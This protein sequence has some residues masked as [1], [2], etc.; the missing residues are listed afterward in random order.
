[1]QT[2]V[3]VDAKLTVKPDE[4]VAL[5][6]K[7]AVPS[8]WFDSDPNVMV[9]L[10]GVPPEICVTAICWPRRVMC[11]V[12][13][14][15]DVFAVKEKLTTPFEMVP[16]VSQVWSLAGAKSPLRDVAAGSTGSSEPAPAD[17]GSVRLAGPTKAK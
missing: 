4:A 2:G 1:M 12:R 8:A 9:W 17:A 16:M 7:A 14:E 11:A 5:T 6:V 13:E 3:V 15:P 10:P